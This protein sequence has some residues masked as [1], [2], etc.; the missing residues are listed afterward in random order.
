MPAGRA[1]CEEHDEGR[2]NLRF[3]DSISFI[4]VIN[5]S[6]K[7]PSDDSM[8]VV[9]YGDGSQKGK[10]QGFDIGTFLASKSQ[11]G[12]VGNDS[13]SSISVKKGYRALVCPDELVGDASSDRCEEFAA[14]KHNLK[15][16][17]AASYVKVWQDGK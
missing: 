8:P 2:H 3:A 12:K 15:Q 16:K 13:A 10:M 4:E 11:F 14:G 17:D 5:L 1:D 7:G 6:D 9:L